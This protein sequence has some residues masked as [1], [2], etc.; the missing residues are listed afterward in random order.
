MG[1]TTAQL[2]FAQSKA[3]LLIKQHYLYDIKKINQLPYGKRILKAR[4][5]RTLV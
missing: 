1:L 4:T 5:N 3:G 2:N